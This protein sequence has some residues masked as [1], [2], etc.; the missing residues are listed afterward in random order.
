[1]PFSSFILFN[2]TSMKVW[3]LDEK[4]ILVVVGAGAIGSSVIGWIAP[5][6]DRSFLLARGESAQVIKKQGLRFYIK[7]KQA[8]AL[9]IPVKVIESLEGVSPPD[10]IVL[11]VKNYDLEK[12]AAMLR[13]QLGSHQPIIVALQNGVENQRILPRYFTRVVHGVVCFNAWRDAPGSVGHQKHGYI[14]L[15]TPQNDLQTEQQQ[16]A[17]IMRL[18]LECT[19]TNRLQDSVHCKLAINLTNALTAL[20]G[21]TLEQMSAKLIWEGILVIKATGFKEHKLGNIPSWRVIRIST[22]LPEAI[23]NLLYKLASGEDTGPNSTFQ[24]LLAG[25]STTELDS[26]NG[27]M[28]TLAQKAG[29]PMPIN[30]TIYEMAKDRFGANFQPITKA[31]LLTAIRKRTHK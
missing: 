2:D 9:P 28:L 17:I 15:G 18:G 26:L 24:D 14:I 21:E 20:V 3:L 23:T 5:K 13:N 25:K 7:D 19:L 12:T 27:Y 8:D 16:V 30:Q 29:I 6:Y 10:I 4:P 1:M 11:A 22:I 31:E